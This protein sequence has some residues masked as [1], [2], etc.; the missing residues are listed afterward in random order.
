M[1]GVARP[2]GRESLAV[3]VGLALAATFSWAS[4]LGS[5][6]MRP[7]TE[8][9][10]FLSMW[11]WMVGASM[12]P[13]VGPMLATTVAMLRPLPSSVRIA[14]TIA[15]AVPYLAVWAGAGVLALG[16]ANSA[17]GRPL[18]AAALVALAGLYELGFLKER[19]LAACRAPIGFF[20]Q[21]GTP[22]TLGRAF[23][24][25]LRHASL[26]LGCCA[27]L[28]LALTAAG[29]FHPLWMAALGVLVL[30]EKTHR[31]GKTV[32]RAVGVALMLAAPLVLIAS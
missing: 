26:C 17:D 30:A 7:V 24:L 9:G 3:A 19:C 28:M 23:A 8:A 13:T 11:L 10:L 22:D 18:L 32:G 27:G 20:L 16:V 12:L 4:L 6:P 31:Y 21:H 5:D 25:G 29:A 2:T 14:H 1:S 15:F